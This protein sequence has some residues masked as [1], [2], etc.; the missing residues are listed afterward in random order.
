MARRT[1]A[2]PPRSA[3]RP[4]AAARTRARALLRAL[5]QRYP[6]AHCELASNAPHELLIAVILSAQSTDAGVN[7]ATPALFAAF[8]TPA[9]YAASTPEAIGEYVRT[10]NF[11]RNKAK[12]IHSAMTTIVR[13]FGGAVPRTMEQLLTLRGVARKTANVVLGEC[14]GVAEGVVVD[15]HVARLSQRFGLTREATPEKIERDL[16]A[17][18]DS[19][20]WPLLSHLLITHGRRVC[21]ARGGACESDSICRAYGSC[22]TPPATQSRG[23]VRTSASASRGRA[24][25]APAPA[26]A[27]RTAPTRSRPSQKRA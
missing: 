7:R 13:E 22:S 23:S 19:S 2:A 10:V 4:A 27:G 8:P 18:F 25:P 26:P 6:D 14:F 16:M 20:E 11:W 17:L 15:T 1:P 9:D 24:R 12:A 5:K 3:E 21:K